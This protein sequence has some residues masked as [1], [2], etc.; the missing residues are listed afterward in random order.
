MGEAGPPLRLSN[1]RP[2]VRFQFGA[3]WVRPGPPAGLR[4]GRCLPGYLAWVHHNDTRIPVEVLCVEGENAR[5]AVHV[6]EG[7][8]PRVEYLTADHADLFNHPPPAPLDPG[9]IVQQWEESL[10]AV[11]LFCCLS[12]CHAQ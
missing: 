9:R 4:R 10:D 12:R 1:L 6:H 2:G 7:D 5:D 8:K 3:G 11:E